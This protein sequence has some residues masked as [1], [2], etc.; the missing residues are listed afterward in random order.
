MFGSLGS[1][2]G[3]DLLEH[4]S[5]PRATA[6]D[7]ARWAHVRAHPTCWGPRPPKGTALGTEQALRA[8]HGHTLLCETPGCEA[9][10]TQNPQGG[11]FRDRKKASLHL[12]TEM[13]TERK[14][15]RKDKKFPVD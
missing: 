1:L 7:R 13:P 4:E 8:A 12:A 2:D 14:C 9:Q 5:V 11:H 6:A 10:P 15:R 3:D